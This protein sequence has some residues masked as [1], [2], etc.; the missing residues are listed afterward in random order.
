MKK[1]LTTMAA[2]SLTLQAN[3]QVGQIANSNEPSNSQFNTQ[4]NFSG[5]EI[6]DLS[7]LANED[8]STL[9]GTS[10]SFACNGPS[11]SFGSNGIFFCEKVELFIDNDSSDNISSGDTL[12]HSVKLVN[13]TPNT[14]SGSFGSLSGSFI[15]SILES[16]LSL[17]IGSVTTTQGVVYSGNGVGDTL[18]GIN[19]GDIPANTTVDVQFS[20]LVIATPADGEIKEVPNQ[21]TFTSALGQQL[22]D[23][24]T[25][26]N[27]YQDPTYSNIYGLPIDAYNDV[28]F[29]DFTEHYEVPTPLTLA[30]EY[31]RVS[32]KVGGAGYDLEDCFQFDLNPNKKL[33]RVVLEDYQTAGGNYDSQLHLFYGLPSP[34]LGIGNLLQTTINPNRIGD[35]LYVSSLGGSYTFSTCLY[36]STP[37]QN[38]SLIFELEIN[39]LIYASG[40][41]IIPQ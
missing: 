23:D 36:E 41:E 30:Y 28:M 11:G 27:L 9:K 5:D 19:S 3:D 39:D 15:D 33:K 38:Y 7:T 14:I 4:P 35:V 8:K 6:S 18:V 17:D 22:S 2:M 16:D 25:T 10:G 29:P 26:Q 37:G 12:L 34:K 21:A 40:F 20:S 32:G 31:M 24:P 1:V 13:Y